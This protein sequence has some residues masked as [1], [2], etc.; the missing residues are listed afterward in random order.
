VHLLG[1]NGNLYGRKVAIGLLKRLR[2]ERQFASPQAL[3][4]QITRDVAHARRA[5]AR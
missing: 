3:I 4:R 5:L 1:F 2:A